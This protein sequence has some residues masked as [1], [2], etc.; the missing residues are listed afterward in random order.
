VWEVDPDALAHGLPALSVQPLVENSIK[1]AFNPR[2]QPGRLVLR[3]HVNAAASQLV[4]SVGDDGPG[5]RL[6]Q[7][8]AS[9]GLGVKTVERRL[10]LEY[11]ERASFIIETAPGAGFDAR[12]SIPLDGS[13]DTP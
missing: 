4:I 11:G 7:V 8:R 2:S 9:D 12:M 1:Y 5:A 6:D 13:Q 3:A 10:Q